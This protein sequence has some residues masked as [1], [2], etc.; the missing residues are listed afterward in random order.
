MKS[1]KLGFAL[2]FAVWAAFSPVTGAMAQSTNASVT[3]TVTDASGSVLPGVSITAENVQTG[4]VTMT[5]TNETGAYGFPT[6]QTGT[7]RFSGELPGFQTR[8]YNDVVLQVAAQIRLNFELD[9]ASVSQSVEV[10]V[11]AESP[12]AQATAT[13]GGV[14][15]VQRVTDLPL[16]DRNV[17]NLV[18]TQAGV[19]GQNFSGN[20]QLN[21]ATSRDGIDINGTRNEGVPI[22]TSVDLIEEVRVVTSPAD[23]ELSRGS[24]QIQLSTRSG[25]NEFHGSL[26]ESIR[27]TA[28][29]ANTWF[30]NLRG[31]PRSILNR[32]QFGGRLG[33]PI[34]KNK[35]FFH[36][37]YDGQRQVS[38]TP[39]TTTTLT[40][41]A[42]QGIFRFYPGVQNGNAN[43]AVPTVDL[44]GNPVRP[45][46]ATG[47]LQSVSV[48]GRDPVRPTFD[49]TGLIQGMI[50]L[51]P[52]PND[53][54]VGDGLNTAGVTWER[55]APSDRDQINL[56]I[57]QNFNQANR[58]TGSYTYEKVNGG[59]YGA[60]SL[61]TVPSGYN[62][63]TN[64][65]LSST[66]TSTLSSRM[67][68]Q[69]VVGI[70]DP[71]QDR[72]MNY[73]KQTVS[74]NGKYVKIADFDENARRT[75]YPNGAVPIIIQP[76]LLSGPIGTQS[77]IYN[78]GTYWSFGDTLSIS[79]G[80]HAFK[81]GFN[82][83]TGNSNATDSGGNGGNVVPRAPFGAG[84]VAVTGINT[85]P[86]I[87]NNQST[88]QNLL[89]D[90]SGSIT[91]VVQ[92]LNVNDS[93]N[94]VY[95]PG[96]RRI[97]DF[98]QREWSAFF[99]DDLKV[100]PSLS[101]YLG[102][103]YDW[104]GVPWD[105]YG[106]LT[107]L[108]GGSEAL[109]GISGKG[110]DVMYQPGVLQG[111]LTR[112]VL[113]GKNSPHPEQLAYAN[114]WNN[115]APAIGMAWSIPYFGQD[116]TVLR[117]GYSIT[118]PRSTNL[119]NV[120][121]NVGAGTGTSAVASFRSGSYINLA[122]IKLPLLLDSKPL[123]II[124]LTDRAQTQRAYDNNLVN[125][126]VQSFNLSVQREVVPGFTVDV[127]YVG[128]KGTKLIEGVDLNEVNI[129]ENGILD[130]F[131]VT[132]AGG[133]APLFDRIFNGLVVNASQGAVNGTTVTGS[134]AL[135]LNSTTRAFLA[136]NNVGGLA[137]YLNT[138]NSFT[139]EAGGLL[140]NGKLP[141][142]FIV[143]NPQYLAT[144]FFGNFGNSNYHSLQ[145]E[146][147]KRF[148]RGWTLNGNYTWSKA[149]GSGD[150]GNIRID[151]RDR[152][153]DHRRLSIDRTHVLKANGTYEFP[154][155]PGRAFLG[156]SGGFISRLVERW[157]LGGIL[158]VS[159]GSPLSITSSTATYNQ[160]NANT[161]VVLD[162]F[163]KDFG[164]ITRVS[165]GVVFFQG[166][167]QRTDP[168][169]AGIT[170]S[171]ASASTMR[172]IVGSN[173]QLLFVNPSPGKL[174]TLG[175][176]YLNGPSTIGLDINLV[177]RIAVRE[178]T[179]VEVRI[180]AIDVLNHPNF[181]NP[182]TDINSSTFGRIT[183]AS[184]NRII[185][186]NLRLTF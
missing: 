144:N 176:N 175:R 170:S 151:G 136:N 110:W 74:L 99:K 109:W 130:A 7:Y 79:S 9:V 178:G 52:L 98:H 78:Q 17:L 76:T 1:V 62:L 93:K 36:F 135:R 127:R 75:F 60:S 179:T 31:T 13:I 26:F 123:D 120:D 183:S 95:E 8:I 169:V 67:V 42:R 2:C 157:Q 167:T 129:F 162:A 159:S 54:R 82:W 164:E 34:V 131:K 107:G 174:G 11:A 16:A 66:L 92:L 70:L 104:Y 21:T 3:G 85:I 132:Q 46:N 100:S 69:F 35:T 19:Q 126:Y 97:R 56:R 112:E 146:T 160:S 37:L 124:P 122:S 77:P 87:G 22:Y 166:L 23:A 138:T 61:P 111:A 141:E 117:A 116:K 172:A 12:L 28:L 47:D 143:V 121:T 177:K 49:S 173:G 63:S 185:V 6:L 57:D 86:G 105:K 71:T 148:S 10:S 65:F 168:A 5:L 114:D 161:P 80:K 181:G 115:F 59:L 108:A 150:A 171:V 165:D 29:N 118:Y 147:A 15:T 140:R 96:M 73:D 24:G 18:S 186:G 55:K 39:V 103:R 182:T 133:D 14:L 4:V 51:H 45:G 153:K 40:A 106:L 43:A 142:N 81:M 88:A 128:S 154:F 58:L 113:V 101:L 64:W 119:S 41:T 50:A 90:L 163:P 152:S 158:T 83:R 134:A 149:M 145:V 68:N 155:G 137:N 102:V 72:D 25:T 84:S 38:T 139:G 20:A 44:N 33:G 27:N 48:F 180:D 53:F 32:N 94:P 89:I 91:S 184:G 30:N 156:N 125:G